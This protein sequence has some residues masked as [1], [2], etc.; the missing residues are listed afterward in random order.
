MKTNV[1]PDRRA[2]RVK[3]EED[4]IVIFDDVYPPSEDS[5]L[6]LDA[7]EVDEKDAILEIGSGTGVITVELLQRVRRVVSVDIDLSAVRNTMENIRKRGLVHAGTVVQSDLITA[8]SP[9]TKFSVIVFNPPYLPRDE[10]STT[11][12]QALVGGEIGNE[13]IL[14]FL[15]QASRHLKRSGRI[16]VVMSSLSEPNSVQTFMENLGLTVDIVATK[17]QFFEKLVVLRGVLRHK[18]TVL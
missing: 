1:C 6:L 9:S 12:D 4:Y 3:D 10:N 2:V 7:L 16:Y 5:Y 8:I 14:R 11:L 17:P 15:D 18:Q 13:V